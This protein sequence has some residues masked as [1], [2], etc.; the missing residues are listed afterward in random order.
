MRVPRVVDLGFLKR[1]IIANMSYTKDTLFWLFL[2][3]YDFY[4]I[5]QN[6]YLKVF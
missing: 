5:L 4:K 1:E 3:K 2:N 6:F